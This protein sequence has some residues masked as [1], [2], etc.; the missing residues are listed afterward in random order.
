MQQLV[1]QFAVGGDR[2][3]R[4]VENLSETD[5]HAH[6]GPGEWSIQELVLHVQDSDAVGI[7]RMKRV[8][9]HDNPTLLAYDEN[10]YVAHLHYTEQSLDDAVALFDIGRRQFSRVLRLL[11]AEAAR[12]TGTHSERGVLTLEQLV[13]TFVNH[14]EHHLRFLL[15]KRQR[16]GKPL[17]L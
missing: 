4:A 8:I 3:R 5:L 12:R 17:T 2:L 15:E 10:L 9:S 1:E 14:L 13:Q 16:L 7:D 11:P 6:P